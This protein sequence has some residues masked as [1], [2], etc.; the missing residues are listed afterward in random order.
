MDV[1]CGKC[2]ECL[3][4]KKQE[5]CFRLDQEKRFSDCSFFV[6]FTYEDTHLTYADD[7]PCLVKRDLQLFFKRLRK[8]LK[9]D[10]LK[11]YCV[12][13][14]GDKWR[15]LTPLGRPHYHALI[16]Y[17]GSL[18]W[19]SISLRIKEFWPLGIAQVLPVL[20]AQGYVTKYI[21][22]FDK[23]EHIVKPFSL[24]SHGLGL[25]YLSDAMSRY[26]RKNLVS[27]AMKP[28]GYKITLP[29]YYKDKIFSPF[30]KLVM[31]KRADLYRKEVELLTLNQIDMM[32]K[33]G[34][35]PFKNEMEQYKLRLYN[36]MKLYRQKK[37]L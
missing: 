6:T 18:D 34:I 28:G 36:S 10:K 22:K 20:G 19:F 13:E 14:Y 8:F 15:P 3:E 11:Y 30:Q 26:H 23:R 32:M 25:D 17:R 5:W 4:Q 33:I 27:F 24:I 35:S 37:K 21:L 31:K 2:L 7:Q 9:G 1:P 12:G 16:F 29:R